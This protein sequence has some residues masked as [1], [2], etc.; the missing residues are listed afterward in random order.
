MPLQP[1]L[2]RIGGLRRPCRSYARCPSQ[3]GPPIMP[4]CIP[5]WPAER[6]VWP[7]TASCIH[8]GC[9]KGRGTS[10]GP[11]VVAAL[12]AIHEC[13]LR[14]HRQMVALVVLLA[15]PSSSSFLPFFFHVPNQGPDIFETLNPLFHSFRVHNI[16]PSFLET[17]ILSF[18]AIAFSSS[19]K[20]QVSI[21]SR[22]EISSSC[23]DR[24]ASMSLT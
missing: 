16:D 3:F 21:F 23:D 7:Q 5:V 24:L 17:W 2:P 6:T 1:R 9:I 22:L 18:V 11:F 20:P 4:F 13:L 10:P 14:T 8:T 15:M 12:A 19:S